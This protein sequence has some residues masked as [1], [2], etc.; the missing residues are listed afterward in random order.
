VDKDYREYDGIEFI[1]RQVYL[2]QQRSDGSAVE[3]ES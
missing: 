1:V 2:S 3:V